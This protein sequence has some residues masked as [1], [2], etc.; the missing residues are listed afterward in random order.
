MKTAW[1]FLATLLALALSTSACPRSKYGVDTDSDTGNED[2]GN[3]DAR[4]EK[5]GK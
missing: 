2:T 5:A 3:E 1:K 4:D